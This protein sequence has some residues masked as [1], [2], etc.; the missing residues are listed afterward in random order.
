MDVSRD[1]NNQ[2]RQTGKEA[3]RH[4][5]TPSHWEQIEVAEPPQDYVHAQKDIDPDGLLPVFL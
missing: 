3:A 2:E 4:I 5:E 1:P